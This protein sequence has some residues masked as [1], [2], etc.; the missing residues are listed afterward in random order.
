MS[1][2]NKPQTSTQA[3]FPTAVVITSIVCATIVFLTIAG[4]IY[5]WAMV[6]R[7]AEKLPDNLPDNVT[8]QLR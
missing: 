3:K 5:S 1:E 2:K 4:M 6:D 8:I 7:I